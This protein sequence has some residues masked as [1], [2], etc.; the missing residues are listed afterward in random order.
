MCWRVARDTIH[1]VNHP[2]IDL[3]RRGE[4]LRLRTLADGSEAKVIAAKRACAVAPE[5]SQQEQDYSLCARTG[6]YHP[7]KSFWK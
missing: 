3:P 2:R 7:T 1:E 5:S 4:G 6:S